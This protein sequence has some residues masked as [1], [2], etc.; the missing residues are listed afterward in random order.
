MAAQ[1]DALI[2][3]LTR[4]LRERLVAV[5]TYGSGFARGPKAAQVRMLVLVD[6]LD[7]AVLDALL[8]ANA[9]ARR[10][11]IHLRLDTAAHVLRCADVLPVFALDLLETRRLIHGTDALTMLAVDPEHLVLRLEQALRVAHRRLLQG[12]LDAEGDAGIARHLRA[13]VRRVLPVLRG[14]AL[15]HGLE[16]PDSRTPQATVATVIG[17]IC[18]SDRALWE[19]LIRFGD[20]L[21]T[22][23]HEALIALYGDALAGFERLVVAVDR[24][25]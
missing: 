1:V 7:A 6:A 10:T 15:V 21:D 2:A 8:P 5:Y 13:L 20:F 12:Y 11:G 25:D 19:R 4:A 9:A 14:L 3:H 18:P 17:R 16:L 22:L 24:R 23:D